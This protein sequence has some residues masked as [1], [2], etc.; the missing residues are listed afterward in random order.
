M[1]R[2]SDLL[3]IPDQSLRH[4]ILSQL[5]YNLRMVVVAVGPGTSDKSVAYW[6]VMIQHRFDTTKWWSIML[7]TVNPPDF[8]SKN[9]PW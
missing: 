3:T 7:S 2:H 5:Q 1:A 6:P 9:R 4:F 8:T